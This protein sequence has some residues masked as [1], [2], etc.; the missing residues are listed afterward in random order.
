MRAGRLRH[1]VTIEKQTSSRTPSGSV[2]REWSDVASVWA[3][4]RP[5]SGRELVASGAV[6]TEV[7][8]RIWLRYRA[9]I[10]T[11]HRIIYQGNSFAITVVIPNAQHTRLELLC[12]GGVRHG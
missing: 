10:T 11:S 12:K 1:R 3:E 2:I 5:I 8:I 9:D 7:T 4:V 6:L